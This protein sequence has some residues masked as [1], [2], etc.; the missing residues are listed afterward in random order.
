MIKVHVI[1]H[2]PTARRTNS[3]TNNPRSTKKSRYSLCRFARSRL[4]PENVSCKFVASGR[5]LVYAMYVQL[6]CCLA[7]RRQD[8]KGSHTATDQTRHTGYAAAENAMET[9]QRS[10]KEARRLNVTTQARKEETRRDAQR[11]FLETCKLQEEQF[12]L[13]REELEPLSKRKVV[14]EDSAV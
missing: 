8:R 5:R 3:P 4:D 6:L 12:Q 9:A 10:G 11:R 1:S 13:E 7:H 2:T 14:G